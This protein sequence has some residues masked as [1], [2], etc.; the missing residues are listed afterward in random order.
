MWFACRSR[1]RQ[2]SWWK[3]S[4]ATRYPRLPVAGSVISSAPVGSMF[5]VII[6]SRVTM[7]SG[8]VNGSAV[9]A[10]A[11]CER[12]NPLPSVAHSH[13]ASTLSP[14][15]TNGPFGIG[16][17]SNCLISHLTASFTGAAFPVSSESYAYSDMLNTYTRSLVS[18]L[19]ASLSA[20]I[21][22]RQRKLQ[23]LTASLLGLSK[24]N[25]VR[26]GCVIDWIWSASLMSNRAFHL[27]RRRHGS[28]VNAPLEQLAC[29]LVA[30]SRGFV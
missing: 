18:H 24:S 12:D 19:L 8:T 20:C 25:V 26:R 10:R 21:I 22:Q 9:V 11:R 2:C 29:M 16:G 3:T 13:I 1:F 30:S 17:R 6:S 7:V 15:P 5:I 28:W 23:T 4:I 14:F 27:R